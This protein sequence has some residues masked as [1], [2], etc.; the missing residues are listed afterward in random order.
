MNFSLNASS[1]LPC[2][3]KWRLLTQNCLQYNEIRIALNIIIL[4][5]NI[6]IC[7][8]YT[9]QW[10][11]SWL[12]VHLIQLDL[13]QKQDEIDASRLLQWE[14]TYTTSCLR[15]LTTSNVQ[16]HRV[17][18]LCYVTPVSSLQTTLVAYISE[19]EMWFERAI[20][21]GML[22]IRILIASHEILRIS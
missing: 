20:H 16:L 18:N 9:R 21:V 2:I 19:Q 13:I 11:L 3:H 7:Y 17:C 10:R 8:L 15:S 22:N 5:T 14:Q 12:R 4:N 6:V 1:I